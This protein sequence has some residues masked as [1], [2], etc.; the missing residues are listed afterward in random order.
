MRAIALIAIFGFVACAGLAAQEDNLFMEWAGQK[1]ADYAYELLDWKYKFFN[2][3]TLEEREILSQIEEV[4]RKTG[5]K[6]WELRADFFRWILSGKKNALEKISYPVEEKLRQLFELL[7]K[8]QKADVRQM[9]FVIR[10]EIILICY[11]TKQYELALEQCNFQAERLQDISSDDYPEKTHYN[12]QIGNLY[13]DFKDY[14]NAVFYFERALEDNVTRAVQVQRPGALNGMG[15]CYRF[16]FDDLDRSDEYFRMILQ[17]EHLQPIDEQNRDTWDG[18]A[19][20]NM[21]RNMLLRGAYDKAIPLLN[22]SIEKMLKVGDL[23]YA[24]GPAIFLASIYLEKGDVTEAKRY[25]DLATGFY[26]QRPRESNL[27][28]IY[29]TLSKYYA[30]TGNIKLSMAYMDST[31]AVNKKIEDA[32][33]AIQLL[34]VEQRK[35]ISE[36]RLKEEQ[37]KEE[38]IRSDGYLRSLTITIIALLLIGGVLV[39]YVVLFLKKQEAYRELVRKSQEWAKAPVANADRDLSVSEKD[40]MLF[41][42]FQRLL[43]DEYL[44]RNSTVTIEQIALMIKTNKTYLSQAIQKCTG[45]NF[46]TCINEYR[47]R[48]AVQLI[49]GDSGKYTL[50]GIGFDVGF[51]DRRT[52]CTVFKKITGLPPSVFKSNLRK[53]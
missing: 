31:L 37:L 50:E 33:N 52:F 46:S 30:M 29:Q 10:Y 3:D 44:Y 11:Q 14:R 19:L 42:R 47:I 6:E 9:E 8:A 17:T 40:R 36:Q 20:G 25:I 35:H 18:I 39:C 24:S 22:S 5:G 48:E 45:Q 49:S 51:N 23:A 43:Q 38:Q 2:L 28:Y 13:L 15:L 16:G 4:A 41:E 21:G 7:E 1:Y 26:A 27:P 53:Q 12:I 32:F 34:R